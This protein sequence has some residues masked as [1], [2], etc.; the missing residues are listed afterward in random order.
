MV[1][2]RA[3]GSQKTSQAQMYLWAGLVFGGSLALFLLG[4]GHHSLWDRDEP[5]YAVATREMIVKDDWVVPT[6]NHINRYDKPILIYWLMSLPMRLMGV[7][8]FSARAVSSFSGACVVALVFFLSIRMGCDKQG[9][10]VAA[11]TAMLNPLLVVIAKASTTDAFLTLTVV[12]A[13]ALHW[14]Q[15]RLGFRWSR[16]LLFWAVVG[17]S[18]LT[19][20]PPGAMVIGFVTLL[21]WAF[22]RKRLPDGEQSINR[23]SSVPRPETTPSWKDRLLRWGA[24]G[25][26]FLAV[27]IPW[28]WA[29]WA[30]T[31]GEFFEIAVGHHVIKRA[32]SSLESHRGPIVYY[33]PVLLVSTLPMSAVVLMG[34]RRAWCRKNHAPERLLWFWIL[35]GLVVFSLVKTK[36]P[37]YV[38]PLTP[39][40]ALMAGL[41]WTA[42][43]ENLHTENPQEN[44]DVNPSR[45][46]WRAGALLMIS[47]GIGLGVGIGAFIH[48]NLFPPLHAP[49]VFMGA[50]FGLGSLLGGVC[51]WRRK[52]LPAV[53]SWVGAM[54]GILL[55]A[56]F[57]VLPVLE[58][59]RPSKI[60]VDW[61]HQRAPEGTQVMAVEYQE[62]S[63]V[64]YW[65][66][67]VEMLGKKEDKKGLNRL[68]SEDQPVA[69][70]TTERRWRKWLD[71]YETPLPERIST[72]FQRRFYNFQKGGWIR[73]VVVGNW[74]LDS[75][76]AD[77][78][79]K[80]TP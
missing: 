66:G 4:N 22:S 56:V 33:L 61:I 75:E 40:L 5:R 37:H 2:S 44:T 10:L 50:L 27:T 58:M 49:A 45:V 26:T 52:I 63:L 64:F 67:F 43:R 72:R 73:L 51:W 46:W 1:A 32:S 57:W 38:A 14:E 47:A 7:N 78:E 11:L 28:A 39:A 30:R 8:E 23:D 3:M 36:L 41:W 80:N 65:G 24:G 15:T 29:A 6:F 21:G 77:L 12:A 25:L 13:I 60:T 59:F 20:G 53:G 54:V 62:P 69:L 18:V 17:A 55:V 42:F 68:L 71:R 31:G 74:R 9:A 16:H 34:L 48:M 19:K 35:P 70:V 76:T 79:R